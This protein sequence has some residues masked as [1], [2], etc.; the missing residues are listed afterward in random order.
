MSSV[1]QRIVDSGE[2]PAGEV[3]IEAATLLVGLLPE[4]LVCKRPVSI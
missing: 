2:E 1:L 3:L 4:V